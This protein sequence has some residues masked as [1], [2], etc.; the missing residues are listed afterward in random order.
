M[1][2][3]QGQFRVLEFILLEGVTFPAPSPHGKAQDRSQKRGPFNRGLSGRIREKKRELGRPRIHPGISPL[4]GT[5]GIIK[6]NEIKEEKQIWRSEM[7]SV[8]DIPTLGYQ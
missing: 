6:G 5:G 3:A 7:T 4:A 2:N 8:W 1:E